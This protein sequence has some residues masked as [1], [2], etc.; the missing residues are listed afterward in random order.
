MV[1]NRITNIGFVLSHGTLTEENARKPI[2]L[3]HVLINE[4]TEINIQLRCMDC[5]IDGCHVTG[6][7]NKEW[8]L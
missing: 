4:P 3:Y 1:L 2:F 7:L 5:P 6:T 8:G